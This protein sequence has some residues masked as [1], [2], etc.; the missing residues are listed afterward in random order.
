MSKFVEDIQARLSIINRMIPGA[1]TAE[2]K[3]LQRERADLEEKLR[4]V[5][6]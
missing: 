4:K 2:R 1:K 6:A 5:T 3:V